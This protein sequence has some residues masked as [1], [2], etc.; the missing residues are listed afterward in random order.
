MTTIDLSGIWRVRLWEAAEK[1]EARRFAES[2]FRNL[3]KKERSL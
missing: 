2:L 1:P 3:T